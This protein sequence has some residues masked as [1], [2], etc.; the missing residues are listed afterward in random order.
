MT[1]NIAY[2]YD[3]DI[4]I[5]KLNRPAK[6]NAM[7]LE[8]WHDL[9]EAIDRA[10]DD[11]ARALVLTGEGDVFCSGDDIGTLR[12]IE[13]EWDV[14]EL[15]KP[16]LDTFDAIE[17]APF[18]VIGQANGSAYGGGLELLIA[19]DLTVVPEGA[20]FSLPET[21]IGAYPFYAAKRLAR[22][23]GRQRAAD[24]VF[25]DR[26]M[27]ATEAVEWGLFARVVS[28][29]R[30][31]ETIDELLTDI[32]QSAPASL[33]I[34]KSWL[35]ASLT[36]PGENQGMRSGLGY[37]FAGRDAHEGAAAFLEGRDPDYSK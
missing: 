34:A 11:E 20:T 10:E 16:F 36:F 8:M 3:N 5:V 7:T 29:E 23:V 14:R 21:Q 26:E 24:L 12:D 37:L 17:T 18:P 19:C 22:L 2:T 1:E 30:V 31:E 9:R 35:N 4:S 27:T 15:T 33:D 13:D 6:L 25:T 32:Q 28:P